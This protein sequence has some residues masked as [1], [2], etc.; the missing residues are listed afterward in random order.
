V[1]FT[2]RPSPFSG[3]LSSSLVWS[4]RLFSSTSCGTAVFF[5]NKSTVRRGASV[6]RANFFS[7]VLSQRFFKDVI[8]RMFFCTL[9]IGRFTLVELNLPFVRALWS[10]RLQAVSV[11]PISFC[12]RAFSGWSYGPAFRSTR[13]HSNHSQCVRAR[14]KNP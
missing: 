8:P 1:G 11:T 14:L 2:L 10:D 3:L 6:V 5:S 9:L 7:N 13:V 4:K 12:Q